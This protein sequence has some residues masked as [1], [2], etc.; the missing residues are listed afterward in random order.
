MRCHQ[1]KKL[2]SEIIDGRLPERLRSEVEAHLAGCVSCS[3]ELAELRAIAGSVKALQPVPVSPGFKERVHDRVAGVI[4]GR[5]VSVEK[6]MAW[7]QL[8]LASAGAAVL[9]LAVWGWQYQ[10]SRQPVTVARAPALSEKVAVPAASEKPDLEVAKVKT[11]EEPAL[12]AKGEVRDVFIQPTAQQPITKQPQPKPAAPGAAKLGM[13]PAEESEKGFAFSTESGVKKEIRER[14]MAVGGD[15]VESGAEREEQPLAEESGCG[16]GST[17]PSEP[18]DRRAVVTAAPSAAGTA[19][20]TRRG[21]AE[22]GVAMKERPERPPVTLKAEGRA[23]GVAVVVTVPAHGRSLAGVKLLANGK[24]ILSRDRL[25]SGESAS[26]LFRPPASGVRQID[27]RLEEE[28]GLRCSY[29]LLI[30]ADFADRE[31]LG[32]KV[33]LS[34]RGTPVREVLKLLARRGGFAVLAPSAVSGKVDIVLT[35]ARVDDAMTLLLENTGY[36][37]QRDGFVWNILPGRSPD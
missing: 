2:F 28:A 7:R 32:A 30:P 18:A 1:V 35:D 9:I 25:A 27:L 8:A 31:K 4:A 17:A 20:P 34:L 13:P 11:E 23:S 16:C 3:S 19:G 14:K 12:E 5:Q 22:L 24:V 36:R 10:Q 6:P 15:M 21:K 37:W 33:S 26:T 29:L